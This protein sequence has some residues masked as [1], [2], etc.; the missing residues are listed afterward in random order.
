[1]LHPVQYENK[2]MSDITDFLASV[3]FWQLNF[4]LNVSNESPRCFFLKEQI[5]SI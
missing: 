5:F 3:L 2:Y 4:F 1:M